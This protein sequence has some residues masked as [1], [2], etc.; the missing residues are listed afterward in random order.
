MSTSQTPN[1]AEAF[2]QRLQ[3]IMREAG[4]EPK[5]S[6][7]LHGF[8]THYAGQPISWQTARNWLRGLFLPQPDKLQ[9][10]AQWLQV[11]PEYLYYGSEPQT[12]LPPGSESEALSASDQAM[13]QHYL[14]STPQAQQMIKSMVATCAQ[15]RKLDEDNQA[16]SEQ[17]AQ[18]VQEN[19]T[20]CEQ[21]AQMTAENQALRDQ[22]RRA[23]ETIT[24][25]ATEL[26]CLRMSLTLEKCI[27]LIEESD[28][29]AAG[30]PLVKPSRL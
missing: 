7:L 8:N 24:D 17:W 3:Q 1:V 4:L 16:W 26:R 28:G 11:Q 13:W 14:S 18:L 15:I 23:E 29:E 12:L 20:L 21:L 2:G 27:P 25:L 30:E 19:G 5:P 6:V 9:A 10:L 22:L